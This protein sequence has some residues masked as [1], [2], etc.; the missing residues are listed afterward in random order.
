LIGDGLL[1]ISSPYTWLE[2]FTPRR[3]W[4][5]GRFRAGSPMS[6]LEGL[7]KKLAKH[8]TAVGEPQEVEFI[9]RE[10]ARMFQHYISQLTL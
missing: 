2:H 8:F 1:A 3:R 7:S 6:S 9:L 4:L 5:G 10:N